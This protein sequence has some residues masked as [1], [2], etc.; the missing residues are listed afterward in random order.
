MD[1]HAGNPA[2][3]YFEALV[4]GP[5]GTSGENASILFE[6]ARKKNRECIVDRACIGA[7]LD[8]ARALPAETTLGIN[9]HASSLAM[10][11]GLVDFLGA[12]LQ[13]GGVSP[14]HLVVE[15]V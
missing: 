8:A 15:V 14:R 4:R 1:V 3:H 11:P 13:A 2:P 6:Y 10:D 7:I 12:A 9:V 5:E